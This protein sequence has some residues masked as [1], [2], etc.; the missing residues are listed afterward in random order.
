MP[1]KPVKT[2]MLDF[3][4][5]S[6]LQVKLKAERW[7]WFATATIRLRKSLFKENDNKINFKHQSALLPAPSR[8]VRGHPPLLPLERER[9]CFTGILVIPMTVLHHQPCVCD[10]ST[11][12]TEFPGMPVLATLDTMLFLPDDR[13]R[14]EMWRK[15]HF[16]HNPWTSLSTYRNLLHWKIGRIYKVLYVCEKELPWKLY[17]KQGSLGSPRTKITGKSPFLAF[18]FLSEALPFSLSEVMLSF[19]TFPVQTCTPLGEIPVPSLQ[20][21]FWPANLAPPQA[22]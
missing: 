15:C 8:A 4:I 14:R 22:L 17:A 5:W 16:S 10:H 2:S 19:F 13:H 9:I 21:N 18:T 3:H 1:E 12:R 7:Q 6:R 20:R 11:L